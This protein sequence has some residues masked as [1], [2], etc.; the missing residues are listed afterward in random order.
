MASEDEIG[1]FGQD[2]WTFQRDSVTTV[3]LMVNVNK[4]VGGREKVHN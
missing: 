4:G 3:L 2:L 1:L